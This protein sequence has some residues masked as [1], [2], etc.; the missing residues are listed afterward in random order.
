M[1]EYAFEEKHFGTS[2]VISIVCPSFVEAKKL[3]NDGFLQMATAEKIFSRFL[4]DSELSK[5][6]KLGTYC[7]SAIFIELLE[8][9]LKLTKDTHSAFNPLTQV[10]NLGYTKTFEALANEIKTLDQSPYRTD[11]DAITID[12]KTNTVTLAPTQ[13]LDFGGIAKG[14]MAEKIARGIKESSPECLG[15]IVNLGGDLYTF[16][17]NVEEK[18]FTFYIFNPITKTELPL[19]VTNQAL[20]TSGTYKRKWETDSGQV[21]HLVDPNTHLN[22]DTQIISSSI[23][24]KSG[25]TAE[26][27]TKYYLINDLKEDLSPPEGLTYLLID[28]T[29]QVKQN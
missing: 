25:A 11:I 29:G 3:A 22:P 7:V 1:E 8:I 14:F 2:A 9:A 20:A 23:I 6:N 16:G 17:L 10:A 19:T 18:P 21:H 28:N 24:H 12:R 5:L 15:V 4:P 27:W 13:Q 26:A